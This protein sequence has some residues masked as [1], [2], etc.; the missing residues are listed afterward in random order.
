LWF[1]SVHP[2]IFWD[3]TSNVAMTASFHIH[4]NTLFID[5]PNILSYI[6]WDADVVIE[7]TIKK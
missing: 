6:I 7:Q 1:D 3:M 5:H 4:F 2:S